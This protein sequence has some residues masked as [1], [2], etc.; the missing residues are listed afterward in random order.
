MDVTEEYY[1]E[2]E[3][4]AVDPYNVDYISVEVTNLTDENIEMINEWS[5][6]GYMD[7]VQRVTNI[8]DLSKYNEE[9][10]YEE[11]FEKG[12]WLNKKL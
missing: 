7:R 3:T 8:P 6:N 5:D 4:L 12:Y 9:T 10:I 2:L 1:K 11:C